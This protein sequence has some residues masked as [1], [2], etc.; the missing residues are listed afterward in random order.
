MSDVTQADRLVQKGHYA[1]AEKFYIKLL[2]N[3]AS[4]GQAY[5]GLGKLALIANMPDR[6]VSLLQKACHLLTN[7]P[8]PFIYLADAFNRVGSEQYALTVL[9]H[10]QQ[11]FPTLAPMLYQLAQQQLMFGDLSNAEQSFCK[12]IENGTDSI[13][14]FA[15][16]D[17]T[18]IRT[19]S[20]ED[21]YL[22]L[23]QS[24]LKNNRLD[25]KELI[26]LNYAM[27]KAQ[28][29]MQEYAKAWQYFEQANT[30]QLTQC[31]F[32]T[33]ELTDFYR[34]V[35][36]TATA[37]V[38]SKTR[39][40][41]NNE[42]IPIFIIGLPRTGSTL[43][44]QI[45]SRHTDISGAGELPYL[46]REVD[47]YL[48][49]QT[50][51]HYPQSMLNL[52]ETQLNDAG[53]L[54]LQK[55]SSHADGKVYVIDKLP[56]NFQSIGLI[57]KLFP[58]AKVINLHRHL[59]DV[60]LSIYKNYFAENE[61]YFCSLEEFKEYNLHYIDLMEHWRTSLPG[62][63]YDLTYEQLIEDK[64]VTIRALLNFCDI[65]WDQAC[66]DETEIHNP[67]KTLSNVQV[68]KATYKTLTTPSQNYLQYLQPF[69]CDKEN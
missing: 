67:I 13:V 44:E 28:D 33:I 54:Y 6:A 7:E 10:G 62:F 26:I 22:G 4:N 15:L 50:Q 52:S 24:R 43:L 20:D 18:R 31:S 56:A 38:L 37:K 57:Y 58:N 68:R 61:P 30:L 27:G 53:C 55:L 39:D 60:A 40:I 49:S 35:K 12:V 48:F 8:L 2:Q 41:G 3:D 34:D 45:L 23:I 19:F 17:L 66:L 51:H 1:E 69:L 47:E 36:S 64:E 32:R 63:I 21:E 46:S 29:D 5:R 11:K 25:S 42:I 65:E 16:H 59:P 14:S 9:E